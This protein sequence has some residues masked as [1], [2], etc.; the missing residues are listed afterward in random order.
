MILGGEKVLSG[1]SYG[2]NAS[3]VLEDKVF[4]TVDNRYRYTSVLVGLPAT[5]YKTDYAFG[6]YITLEKN[7]VPTTIYGPVVAKSIYSLAQQILNMGTYPVGSEADVFLRK[8]ITDA[9]ALQINM[10]Q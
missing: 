4:E 5:E 10:A 3:G 2:I 6:G 8:I 9:D 1:L 7:G